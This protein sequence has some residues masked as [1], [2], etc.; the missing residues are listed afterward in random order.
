MSPP[1]ISMLSKLTCIKQ[2]CALPHSIAPCPLMYVTKQSEWH[3]NSN[4]MLLCTCSWT[5]SNIEIWGGHP[6]TLKC[7]AGGGRRAG[8]GRAGNG[9]DEGRWGADN[10]SAEKFLASYV[11]TFLRSLS[12]CLWPCSNMIFSIAFDIVLSLVFYVVYPYYLHTPSNLAC[13]V[14]FSIVCSKAFCIAF[15]IV[16]NVAFCI[17]FYIAFSVVLGFSWKY[18]CPKQ[19]VMMSIMP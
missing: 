4:I 2:S 19:R 14:T 1:P 7:G 10:P 9:S 17:A 5:S 13:R 8:K 12:P 3:Q 15:C 18:S 16:F 6:P 11:Y